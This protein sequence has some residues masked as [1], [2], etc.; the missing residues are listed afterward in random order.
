LREVVTA[1]RFKVGR[2]NLGTPKV[3]IRVG[4]G[5]ATV[6][7]TAV[8]GATGYRMFVT[9]SDGRSLFF[10]RGSRTHS[11]ALPAAARV[12]ARVQAVGPGGAIGRFGA[13]TAG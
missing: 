12:Q 7:W 5:G 2:L 3:K 4:T 8:R 1:A 6:S 9:T 13:A 11:I 10:S